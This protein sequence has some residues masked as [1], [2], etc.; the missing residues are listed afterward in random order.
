MKK[1]VI[2]LMMVFTS[3]AVL[4]QRPVVPLGEYVT[5]QTEE[6][7]DIAV[8]YTFTKDSLYIDVY[9]S[10]CGLISY[11]LKRHYKTKQ[12]NYVAIETGKHPYTKKTMSLKHYVK[13]T[14]IDRSGTKWKIKWRCTK[15]N[16][17]THE[18]EET[19]ERLK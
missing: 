2:F 6:T 3:I 19:I 5:I 11:K 18:F 14:K 13:A 7:E 8:K 4:A 16:G 17:K 9:P 15:Y 10:G 12:W 1:I